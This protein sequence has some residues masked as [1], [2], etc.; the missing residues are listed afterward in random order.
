MIFE[1][2]FKVEVRNMR[3]TP[4]GSWWRAEIISGNGRYYNVR[5]QCPSPDMSDV[6]RV[7]R[8]SI[9]PCPPSNKLP[10][11]WE[12]GDMIEAF[13]N[14]SWKISELLMVLDE[15]HYT[16]RLL[17]SFWSIKIHYLNVRIRQTWEDGKWVVIRKVNCLFTIVFYNDI[18]CTFGIVIYCC[19]D[20]SSRSNII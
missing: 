16:V 14:G 6:E 19:V 4:T 3:E 15:N 18:A 5:Y 12:T 1:K 10:A 2:G 20:F 7:S 8:K 17:G 11:D 9:R 13:D